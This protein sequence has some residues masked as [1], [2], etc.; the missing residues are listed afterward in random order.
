MLRRLFALCAFLLVLTAC[1][2]S[3]EEQP[4]RPAAA[5]PG[6]ATAAPAPSQ[7][8]ENDYRLGAEDKVKVTVYGEADLSGEFV[9]DSSG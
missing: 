5:A 7:S 9:V 3:S 6:A 4:P 8:D 2:G 1:A